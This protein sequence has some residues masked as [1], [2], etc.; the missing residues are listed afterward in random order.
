MAQMPENSPATR[1]M[2][3]SMPLSAMGRLW[4]DRAKAR[5]LQV[6]DA[7]VVWAHCGPVG[8]DVLT[9]LLAGAEE[10]SLAH[11]EALGM[12]KRMLQVVVEAVDNLQRHGMGAMCEADFALLVHDR[13]G[14]RLATGNAVPCSTGAVLMNR[15]EILGLMGPE[16]I[17]GHYMRVLA[18]NARTANG[19]AGLGLF[20][21]ARKG[22]ALSASCASLGPFISYFTLEVSVGNDGSPPHPAA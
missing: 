12:R 16:D 5:L 10:H 13:H 17:K 2:D 7:I 21:L 20:T 18:M 14:Y 8:P 19:G 15:V 1:M 11:G 22:S 9:A 4:M 3:S 6:P